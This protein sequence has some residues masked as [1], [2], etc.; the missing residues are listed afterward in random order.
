M[1]FQGAGLGTPAREGAVQAGL[2]SGASVQVGVDG[3][4]LGIVVGV[5]VH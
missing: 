2:K 4:Q 5:G 3:F 1:P